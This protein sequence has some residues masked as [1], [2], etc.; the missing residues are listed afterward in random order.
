[1]GWGGVE[2]Q[3]NRK[4]GNHTAH[5][6]LIQGSKVKDGGG[7]SKDRQDGQ[8][9]RTEGDSMKTGPTKDGKLNENRGKQHESRRCARSKGAEDE[10]AAG[11]KI[12][13][14]SRGDQIVKEKQEGE[15]LGL[16]GKQIRESRVKEQQ[17]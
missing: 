12:V 2:W 16:V 10:E 1:V 11:T 7:Q 3:R 17:I 6:V 13:R 9:G 14:R 8:E 4:K 15:G 5:V